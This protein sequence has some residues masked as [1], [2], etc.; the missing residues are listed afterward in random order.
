MN[1]PLE[2]IIRQELEAFD[3]ESPIPAQLSDEAKEFF[4]S[5]WTT[6]IRKA[7]EK[8]VLGQREHGGNFID[9]VDH[10]AEADNELIDMINYIGGA[11]LK[12]IKALHI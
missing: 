3:D 8:M 1:T 10:L 4:V 7:A 9:D 11:K 2:N 6:M 5:R 12:V